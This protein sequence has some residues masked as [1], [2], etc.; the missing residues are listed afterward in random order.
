MGLNVASTMRLTLTV[1]SKQG[2]YSKIDLCVNFH[3]R[4]PAT[5]LLKFSMRILMVSKACLVGTYQTKLE[6]IARQQDIELAVIVPPAWR[7]P[8]G[9]VT[10]ERSH[11]NGYQLLVDPIRFNGQF[12]LHYY[13]RL[14]ERLTSFRPDVLHVDEEPYNLAT[15]L[16]VRQAKA[17]GAKTLFFTWQNIARHYPIPFRWLEQQVLA[18]VDFAIMG[19]E[20]AV[21]VWQSKGYHGPY[22][23]IPQFGVDPAQFHP[24]ANRDP[25]RSFTIGITARRLVPEK[26]VDLLLHAAAALPGVW[27]LQIAGDG[28]ARP[29]L[30][31]LAERLGISD[32]V[33][34][35]GVIPSEQMPAFLQQMDVVVVPSRTLPNWKEQFGRVLIEAM[36][37]EAA[38]IGSDSGEIPHVIG[39]AGLVFREEDVDGLVGH[40]RYLMQNPDA[41]Q[42]LGVAGRERVLASY[43][44]A[45]VAANTVEV[46]RSLMV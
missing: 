39:Q 46:Y 38:V 22:R 34:F 25:G 33:A 35:E 31:Q 15:W 16:A 32:R 8:A 37:C 27:R 7:D 42:T 4:K 11:T 20:A 43:T 26:G 1:L 18:S 17:V 6:E 9:D 29:A 23:V 40:L 41:R 19:N 12:H 36:A 44:Q 13:P 10:L 21:D 14:K 5:A 24:P 3:K 45:Q 30:M 2:N 28:P